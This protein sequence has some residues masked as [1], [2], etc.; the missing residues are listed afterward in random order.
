MKK[1]ILLIIIPIIILIIAIVIFVSI[2]ASINKKEIEGA[3]NGV[4]ISDSLAFYKKPELENVKQIRVLKK[5]ENV[6][7]LD[8]FEKNGVSW[9][10]VKGICLFRWS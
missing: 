6:Y 3:T 2:K 7:I 4:V 1:K 8:E 9:Y 10:K 5:S